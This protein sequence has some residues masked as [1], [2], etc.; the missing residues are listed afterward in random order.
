MLFFLK[1]TTLPPQGEALEGF[2]KTCG[3]H[4]G[5]GGFGAAEDGGD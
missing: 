5:G 1:L 2:S 4:L 3:L